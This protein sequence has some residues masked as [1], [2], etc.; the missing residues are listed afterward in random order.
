MPLKIIPLISIQ[1]PLK[2]HHSR[3]SNEFVAG[4]YDKMYALFLHGQSNSLIFPK[5]EAFFC[6]SLNSPWMQNKKL[7]SRLFPNFKSDW[8]PCISI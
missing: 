5:I 1:D 2:G 4:T 7:L 6:S 3:W 8:E